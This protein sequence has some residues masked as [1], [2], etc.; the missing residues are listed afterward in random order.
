MVNVGFICEGDSEKIILESPQFL[1]YIY[2]LNLNCIQPVI[3]VGGGNNLLP[4]HLWE[5]TQKLKNNGA[6][7]IIILSDLDEDRCITATKERI[8]P[9][10][11]QQVIVAVQQL[12]AW[13]LADYEA[14]SKALKFKL[15]Y[16]NPEELTNP[17][18]YIREQAIENIGRGIG[19]K[20]LFTK[21]MLKSG[22]EISKA[23]ENHNCASAKY[24][25]DKLENLAAH[26]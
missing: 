25:V 13:F 22:F 1:D 6:D 16:D 2:S 12:E 15:I 26:K 17:F 18:Q 24:F 20:V 7:Y 10:D 5:H 3:N 21:R 8:Q 9:L 23:A 14:I 19:S 4:K 11:D